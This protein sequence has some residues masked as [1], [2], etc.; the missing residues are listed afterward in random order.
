MM[1][2]SIITI[3]CVLAAV[4]LSSVHAKYS[5]GEVKGTDFHFVDKFCFDNAGRGTAV[6][7]FHNN[8]QNET[9]YLLI[10]DDEVGNW[11]YVYE[12]YKE[13]SCE[14]R[15][16]RSA[17][18]RPLD[19]DLTQTEYFNDFVRPHFWYFALQACSGNPLD[20]S[21]TMHMT[22]FSNSTWKREFSYDEQGLEGLFLF[23]WLLFIVGAAAHGYAAFVLSKSQAYHTIVKLLT[24]IVGLEWFYIFFSFCHYAAYSDNGH[25]NIGLKNFADF[26]DTI[27]Q[28]LIIL[29]LVLVAKGY[30]I[31]KSDIEGKKLLFGGMIVL[32][33]SYLILYIWTKAG[34]DPANDLFEYE[35]VPGIITVILRALVTGWFVW[36]LRNTYLEENHAGKREFYLAFGIV[37]S[38]WLLML[39]LITIIAAALDPW[40]RMK[41]VIGMYVT[42][43]AIGLGIFAFVFW[44]SRI[45]NYFQVNSRLDIAGT[46]PYDSI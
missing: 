11:T 9:V 14:Q 39:P 30:C 4:L 31:S 43:N 6:F 26:L 23:W 44:P 28:V 20:V 1:I 38:I 17:Y 34:Q 10:L 21:Y 27:A 46:I 13:M 16:E 36:E 19:Q 42:M 2:R 37:Y 3:L 33:I 12:H 7:D 40:V 41:V 25:G 22:Q 32:S 45:S 35:T 15:A 18:A 8:I 24:V 29:L 5:S